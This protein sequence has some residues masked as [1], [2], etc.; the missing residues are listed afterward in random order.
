MKAWQAEC[1]GAAAIP[2]EA[3]TTTP[4]EKSP[5]FEILFAIG[6]LLVS[7]IASRR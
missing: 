1:S 2:A 5:C 3:K 4:P 7:L 6:A